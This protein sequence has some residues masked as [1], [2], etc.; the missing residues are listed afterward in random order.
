[1]QAD[2]EKKGVNFA[3]ILETAMQKIV[4][5]RAEL[6]KKAADEKQ[7]G[8]V[9]GAAIKTEQVTQPEVPMGYAQLVACDDI[10]LEEDEELAAAGKAKQDGMES[11][12]GTA[13]SSEHKD[14]TAAA[15]AGAEEAGSQGTEMDTGCNRRKAEDKPAED[16]RSAKTIRGGK[17]GG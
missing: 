7:E 1:V 8:A 5:R 6:A 13:Q 12:R 9:S 15:A 10:D 4:A 3:A 14:S 16:E 11:R 17:Q 2:L